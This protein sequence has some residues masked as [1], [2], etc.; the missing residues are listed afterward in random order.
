[1]NHLY[2][3]VVC[4]FDTFTSTIVFHLVFGSWLCL[5]PVRIASWVDHIFNT[6]LNGTDY[7]K[8]CVHDDPLCHSH[9]EEEW[10]G[11]SATSCISC[12][13]DLEH[14]HFFLQTISTSKGSY[15]PSNLESFSQWNCKSKSRVL[16]IW[17][18]QV[19]SE[20]RHNVDMWLVR[21]HR[22]FVVFVWFR[23]PGYLH[24]G[25]SLCPLHCPEFKE[26]GCDLR[27]SW[28]GGFW[29][30]RLWRQAYQWL[31]WQLL[32][33]VFKLMVSGRGSGDI[34]IHDCTAAHWI[35]KFHINSD[36]TCFQQCLMGEAFLEWCMCCGC[37]YVFRVGYQMQ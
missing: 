6:M 16:P 35:S 26:E 14:F 28:K 2:D 36:M 12:A 4:I 24:V 5:E 34:L 30:F 29:S 18:S 37:M 9:S 8:C 20:C 19:T 15:I 22:M 23:L 1:M 27:S 31:G 25:T 33:E 3:L 17:V 7:G 11:F 10:V 13:L 32:E 21:W